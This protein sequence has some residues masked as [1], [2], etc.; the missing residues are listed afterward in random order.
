MSEE[1][2]DSLFQGKLKFFQRRS[3][4]R[5]SLDA[6]LLAHFVSMKGNETVADLGTGNGVIPLLLANL[7]AQVSITG[8]EFQPAMAERAERNVK[9]NDLT[10][11][12]RICR[13]DVRAIRAVAAAASFDVVVCN[14]PFRKPS[15]GRISPDDEKRIARHELQ[16]EL[17]DFLAAATFLLRPKGRMALIY[18]AV[19]FADLISAMRHARI[20]PKR[21]RMV[22][23]F[24]DAEASL[25][26]V[27]GVKGGRPGMTVDKPLAIYRRAKEYTDEVSAMITGGR[28]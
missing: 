13:G 22:H 24:S 21:L 6:L 4:Y 17:G 1:T 23:S 16:G 2:L 14:P 10:G 8:F 3:G 7:H 5:F 15:S 18:P 9:L 27:E 20:E 19:R 28:L 26:L 11:R 12:I 25:V